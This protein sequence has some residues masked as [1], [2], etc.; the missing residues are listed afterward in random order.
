MLPFSEKVKEEI[1]E[2]L[3]K[4]IKGSFLCS[5]K[6]FI[7]HFIF[8]WMVF[9]ILQLKLGFTVAIAASIFSILPFIPTWV[10]C[11]PHAIYLYFEEDN[12]LLAIL[13]PVTYVMISNKV[14]N[15]I[16]QKSINIH[17]Y[18]TGLS[19]VLGIYAFDVQGIIYGPLL[20]CIT[21]IVIELIKKYGL[22]TESLLQLYKKKL[23]LEQLE[24]LEIVPDSSAATRR[25]F[26]SMESEMMTPRNT[27]IHKDLL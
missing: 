7:F 6:I 20:M 11:I 19:I 21:L 14:Y 10:L 8:T 1:N 4:S 23:Y 25:R 2:A 18:L 24:S 26:K 3:V 27:S 9:D 16:Y 22:G 17:P 15:D 13:F 5:I 12:L